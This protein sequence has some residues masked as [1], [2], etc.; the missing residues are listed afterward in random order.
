MSNVL[1]VSES[2]LR[3]RMG[4]YG[5]AIRGQYAQ[6]SDNALDEEILVIKQSHP[7]CGYRMVMGYL[8]AR[9]L[10]IQDNRVRRAL[11][12]VDPVGVAVRWSRNRSIHRR[13]YNVPHPNALWHLDGNMSLVR[14]GFVVH[15]CIDGYSRLITFLSC[16]TN[17]RAATVLQC[18][19]TAGQ[20][21]GFPSRVRSDYGGENFDVAHF[22]IALRG[23]DTTY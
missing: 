4:L 19:L 1:G 23:L 5:L 13:K 2:T 22:M 10:R 8:N 7:D 15:G 20:E 6:I 14:W 11:D 12:L 21:F 9:G 16:S 18:F 17:N 3:R